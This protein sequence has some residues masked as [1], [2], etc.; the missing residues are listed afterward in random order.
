MPGITTE[1]R[2]REK[3]METKDK[4]FKDHETGLRKIGRLCGGRAYLSCLKSLEF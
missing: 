4:R 2:R 3:R 1:S